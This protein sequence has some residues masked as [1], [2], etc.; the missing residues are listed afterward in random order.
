MNCLMRFPCLF[1]TMACTLLAQGTGSTLVAF[2]TGI[3]NELGADT[4]LGFHLFS[5]DTY[6]WEITKATDLSKKFTFHAKHCVY[7]TNPFG[8]EIVDLATPVC[9]ELTQSDAMLLA[10][11]AAALVDFYN[12]APEVAHTVVYVQR[13]ESIRPKAILTPNI[14]VHP[15]LIA[16]NGFT[17]DFLKYD[18]A[19]NQ[20]KTSV[21]IADQARM[22]AVRPGSIDANEVWVGHGGLIDQISIV[23]L[24][25]GKVLA[26]I[27]TPS[28]DPNISEPTGLV[29]TNG[30]AT[31][32][33]TA[34]FFQPDSAGNAGALVVLDAANRTVLSTQMLKF[35]PEALLMAPDGLT[36]YL[37]GSR[38]ITYYDVLSGTS[39]LTAP[40]TFF[41]PNR[42]S[43]HPDGTRIFFD[44]GQQ[45]GV[46]DV[47]T[48]KITQIKYG[49]PNNASAAS[50]KL[51]QDG[52]RIYVTDGKGNVVVLGTR[53]GDILST[54]QT[55][56][57]TTEVLPGPVVN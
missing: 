22:F 45:L 30:G 2:D 9:T 13:V 11:V 5:A 25:A 16:F 14:P 36:A 32:L 28:L 3:I 17:Y 6:S 38:T 15:Q 24:A 27:P 23:D 7:A 49:L 26:T 12:L 48:R 21:V 51:T 41:S 34:K 40:F 47:I 33:Y 1:L 44:Q 50:V 52:S 54:Y 20:I 57:T 56:A 42:V 10:P 37:M 43:I 19:T 53:Y 18:L 8:V 46:F 4:I 55:N 39:D 29:F 31:A 35:F